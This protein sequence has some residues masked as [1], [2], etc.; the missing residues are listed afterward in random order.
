[1]TTCRLCNR[2]ILEG[3]LCNLCHQKLAAYT[4]SSSPEKPTPI[5]DATSRSDAINSDLREWYEKNRETWWQ[6][7]APFQLGGSR[8]P[9]CADSFMFCLV[10]EVDR[11]RAKYT[12]PKTA[13][14]ATAASE[15]CEPGRAPRPSCTA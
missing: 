5:H 1:M 11:L 15:C 4:I 14:E 13:S 10:E 3:E 7:H 9:G 2:E 12:P 6:R 8:L